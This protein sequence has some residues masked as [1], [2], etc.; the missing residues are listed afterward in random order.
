[1]EIK[2]YYDA[3]ET[4]VKIESH[5]IPDYVGAVTNRQ[6]KQN[7]YDVTVSETDSVTE[8]VERVEIG[9]RDGVW[10]TRSVEH[11]RGDEDRPAPEQW[12]DT[13][14]TVCVV[15]GHRMREVR[16]IACDGEFVWPVEET[17]D[18]SS[19]GEVASSLERATSRLEDLL[20]KD[21]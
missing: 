7:G 12:R 20:R 9:E 1:M 18:S 21:K 14:R 15:P 2:V 3:G 8:I 6:D 16:R 11:E 17:E 10:L 5:S 13:T 19:E 4:A